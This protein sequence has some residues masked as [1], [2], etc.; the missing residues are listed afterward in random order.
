[1][2]DHALFASFADNAENRASDRRVLRLE[3]RVAISGGENGI[4]VRN[5]SQ[6]GLLL[7]GVAG[8]ATGSE[9]EVELRGGTR[10]RAEVMWADDA[11][12]GCRFLTPLSKAQLSAALL[13]SA[14]LAPAPTAQPLTPAHALATLREHWDDAPEEE[15]ASPRPFS[16]KLPLGRRLWIIGG[17]GMAGW[18]V[19]AAA[20]WVLL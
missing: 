10:H 2:L 19:P 13:R 16:G 6:S 9:I 12:F 8:V 5:L 14:P 15:A 17:L 3:A 7:E 4:Q 1:M 11:L 18:A 20:A